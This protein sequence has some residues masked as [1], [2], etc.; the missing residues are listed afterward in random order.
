[1]LFKTVIRT[2]KKLMKKAVLNLKQY[3]M[4]YY[5][6]LSNKITHTELRTCWPIISYVFVYYN[7]K[8]VQYH[9]II[10]HNI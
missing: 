2:A 7:N 10:R 6:T 3:C 8:T 1:M 5:V 4:R 9:C